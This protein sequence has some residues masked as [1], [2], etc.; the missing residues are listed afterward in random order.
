MFDLENSLQALVFHPQY[1]QSTP[2]MTEDP[3]LRK[4]NAACLFH[5]KGNNAGKELSSASIS[6]R[7][8]TTLVDSHATLQNS[9]SIQGKVKARAVATSHDFI[10]I[11]N[12]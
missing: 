3:E 12:K 2:N 9:K 6:R 11:I 8:C 7:I 4:G 10:T 5:S 1:I